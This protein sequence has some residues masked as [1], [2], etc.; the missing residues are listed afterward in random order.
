MG[1]AIQWHEGA[2]LTGTLRAGPH[3][4]EWGDP[5]EAVG[6]VVIDGDTAEIAGFSAPGGLA[7]ADYSRCRELIRARCRQ[8]RWLVIERRR[9]ERVTRRRYRL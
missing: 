9:G 1:V 3:F 7:L 4:R 6:T 8:A 2:Q 5:Y